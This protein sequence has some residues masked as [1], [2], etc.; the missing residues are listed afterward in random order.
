MKVMKK[1]F[2]KGLMALVMFVVNISLPSWAGR[3][4]WAGTF[5][6][7]AGFS[8]SGQARQQDVKPLPPA[9][10]VTIAAYGQIKAEPEGDR[11]L[12]PTL[13]PELRQKLLR[14]QFRA[15]ANELP[16]SPWD[17]LKLGPWDPYWDIPNTDP[18]ITGLVQEITRGLTSD[19]EK[20]AAIYKWVV[21]NIEY[22]YSYSIFTKQ[23][24]LYMRARGSATAFPSFW[25]P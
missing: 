20:A 25:R 7:K 14:E 12:R 18:E 24:P 6:G 3:C 17:Y 16:G 19:K 15:A 2:L 22:D 5:D 23:C 8:Q 11:L 9:D 10:S 21:Q 13:P 1:L 4:A